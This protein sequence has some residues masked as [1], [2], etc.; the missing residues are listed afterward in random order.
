MNSG[1]DSVHWLGGCWYD[2]IPILLVIFCLILLACDE[3][4]RRARSSSSD[5]S[6]MGQ[7]VDAT[8]PAEGGAE[9]SD[10]NESNNT[11]ECVA[12]CLGRCA[13]PDG[14]G[15]VALQTIVKPADM[16]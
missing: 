12:Q 1:G 7:T 10:Q 2:Q 4:G 16:Q 11:P 3:E 13:G 8:R 9:T 15:G 14:C 5:V 6:P